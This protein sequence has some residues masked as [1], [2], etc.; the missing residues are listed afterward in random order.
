MVWSPPPVLATVRPAKAGL[1][2]QKKRQTP[3]KKYDFSPTFESHWTLTVLRDLG[4]ESQA[5]ESYT[6]IYL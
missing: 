1:F 3:A 2:W 6:N 4:I 5:Q